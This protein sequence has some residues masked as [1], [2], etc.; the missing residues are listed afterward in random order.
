[1]KNSN[2]SP[3][4]SRLPLFATILQTEQ[5]EKKINMASS[6]HGFV[7]FLANNN[8]RSKKYVPTDSEWDHPSRFQGGS[9][10]ELAL[11]TAFSMTHNQVNKDSSSRMLG[12]SNEGKRARRA[13]KENGTAPSLSYTNL[14]RRPRASSTES[15]FERSPLITTGSCLPL[16]RLLA[17]HIGSTT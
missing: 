5:E 12:T 11:R 13:R 14:T 4:W 1:M 8:T 6:K 10:R 15:T 7:A 3:D 9:R 2:I 16:Q 17:V